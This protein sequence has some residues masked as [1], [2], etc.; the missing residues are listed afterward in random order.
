MKEFF[1]HSKSA[2]TQ[3]H[4]GHLNDRPQGKNQK[5][6]E[7]YKSEKSNNITGIHKFHLKCDSVNGS[8]LYGVP[9]HILFSFASDKPPGH[10]IYKE[11]RI[12]FFRKVKQHV[13]SRI[14]FYLEDDEHKPINFNGETISFT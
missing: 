11:P 2:F 9:E 6:P 10:K 13:L 4:S 12:K 1:F 7:I 8:I 3:S 5:I 14:T